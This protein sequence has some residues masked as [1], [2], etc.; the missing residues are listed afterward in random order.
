MMA[1]ADFPRCAG[2]LKAMY[3]KP[4]RDPG[5]TD[6]W[7]AVILADAFTDEELAERGTV[8]FETM[9]GTALLGEFEKLLAERKRAP[10]IDRA[11]MESLKAFLG[12]RGVKV[13]KLKGDDDYRMAARALWGDRIDERAG[14]RDMLDTLRKMTKRQR[15]E[16]RDNLHKLPPEW[17]AA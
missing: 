17:R 14:L 8:N 10:K 7:C 12:S 6:Y 1:L 2:Y 5:L 16:A 3:V 9:D 15:Q 11:D 4:E 13:S